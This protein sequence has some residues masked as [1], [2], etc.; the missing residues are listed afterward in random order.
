MEPLDN[1]FEPAIWAE[2]EATV[3]T[4]KDGEED[5][6]DEADVRHH[7]QALLVTWGTG[8]YTSGE[9]VDTW[10]WSPQDGAFANPGAPLPAPRPTRHVC[11]ASVAEANMQQMNAQ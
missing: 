9:L 3:D 6:Q 5:A 8:T 1:D 2:E 4:A 7:T 11:A 10:P